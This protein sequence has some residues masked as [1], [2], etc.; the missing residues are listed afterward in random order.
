VP[1]RADRPLADPRFIG[2]AN[3]NANRVEALRLANEWTMAQPSRAA[4]VAALDAAGVP[5]APVATIDEVVAD[6]QTIARNMIVEQ[7]HP[8][9]GKVKLPNLPFRFSDCDTTPRRPAP[10]MGQHNRTIAAE[11]GFTA[12]DIAAL[13]ADGVLYAEEA[14]AT[15]NERAVA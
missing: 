13:Q 1:G 5:C 7:E 15:L 4:C 2:Q 12:Q 8:V 6:P 10:L 14:V 3:R 9:L 11:L